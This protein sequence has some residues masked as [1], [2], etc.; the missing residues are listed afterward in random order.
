MI[1]EGRE[2]SSDRCL[3]TERVHTDRRR[4]TFSVSPRYSDFIKSLTIG[5][6]HTDMTLIMVCVITRQTVQ[7]ETIVRVT[8]KL[9]TTH[10]RCLPLPVE[11]WLSTAISTKALLRT[12]PTPTS[13]MRRS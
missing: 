12:R 7:R 10:E 8:V 3:H 1:P 6:L 9:S 4:H 13:K 5:A 11:A 2:A